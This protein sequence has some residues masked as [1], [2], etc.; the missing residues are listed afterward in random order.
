MIEAAE[1]SRAAN[2]II[3]LLS[4]PAMLSIIEPLVIYG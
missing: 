1:G 2:Q 3:Y 4:T